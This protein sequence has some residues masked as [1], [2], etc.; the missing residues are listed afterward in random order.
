MTKI[1]F[2]TC[3]LIWKHFVKEFLPQP[4]ELHLQTATQKYHE[5]WGFPN[6]FGAID[7]KHFGLKCP[8]KSGSSQFNYLHYFS[9]VLMAVA[10]ADK[11]FLIVEVGARGK[12]SDG[13]TFSASQLYQQLEANEFNVLP[14]QSIPGT[15]AKVPIVLIGDEA[16]PLKPYIMRP[17]RGSQLTDEEEVFNTRLSRARKTIECAFG[18]LCAKWRFL[19]KDMEIPSTEKASILVLAACVLHNIVRE[20][21]G[22]QDGDY[23]NVV[24]EM[25]YDEP[26]HSPQEV[27]P[28][29]FR[30]TTTLAKD[31]REKFTQYFNQNND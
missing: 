11:K 1:V 24:N 7:G 3:Q 5:M 15:N 14:D 10:D 4:T 8:P 21:D 17:Y 13:G 16:F 29:E 23:R 31:I 2:G 25:E 18:I 12:Q 26:H 19:L 30:N 9:V 27:T 22:L 28:G 20:K 6:C